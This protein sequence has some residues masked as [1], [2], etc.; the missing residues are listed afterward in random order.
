[1]D[2]LAY[3]KAGMSKHE[4]HNLFSDVVKQGKTTG[5]DQSEE[6]A[7]YTKMNLQRYERWLDHT[8][9]QRDTI[10]TLEQYKKPVYWIVIT[11]AWCGDAA[12]GIPFIEKMADVTDK[13]QMHYLLRDE[14][15][16]LIDEYSANGGRSIPKLIAIDDNGQELFNWGPRPEELQN[17]FIKAKKEEKSFE[18]M[19]NFMQK[20]YNED[21]GKQIQKEILD[22]IGGRS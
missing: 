12:H 18:E 9:L 19:V 5:D 21:Q 7:H 2:L 1:M 16:E 15:T 17:W 20:W 6:I 8:E 3:Y 10:D 11:E 14:N 22:L 4:F 13:I